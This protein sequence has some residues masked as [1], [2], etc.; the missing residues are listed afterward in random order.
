MTQPK[1]H[2]AVTGG[3]LMVLRQGDDVFASLE[4]LMRD[5]GIA[6][7]SIR[8]FGFVRTAGFGY[9]DF[10]RG[11]YEPREFADL[12]ITGLTGTLAWKDAKPAI[13][14]HATGAGRDFTAVGGHVLGLVVGRGSFEL[15]VNVYEQRL[16]RRFEE[17]IGANVLQLG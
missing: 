13:H 14:A 17:D 9:F 15:T 12:E 3:F 11:D 1:R 5:E 7:A 2:I 16:E 6:S 8:G 4:A 10:A